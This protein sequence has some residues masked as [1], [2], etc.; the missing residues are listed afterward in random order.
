MDEVRLYEPPFI[1]ISSTGPESLFGAA[2]PDRLV[3]VLRDQ[4]L[5]AA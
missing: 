4:R 2:Q 3:A 5:R 1:Y